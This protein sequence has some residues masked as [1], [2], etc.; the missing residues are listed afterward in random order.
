MITGGK[1]NL[2]HEILHTSEDDLIKNKS[3]EDWYNGL[4]KGTRMGIQV[5]AS[6]AGNLGYNFLS[7]KRRTTAG[8]VMSG[9][10]D[11]AIATGN[12][13]AIAGGLALKGIGALT[14]NIWGNDAEAMRRYSGHINGIMSQDFSGDPVAAINN[15]MSGIKI[16]RGDFG[17]ANGK[18]YRNAVNRQEFALKKADLSG[19]NALDINNRK[20]INDQ[21]SVWHA[22]GGPLVE[23]DTPIGYS[24]LNQE[25]I[26][27]KNKNRNDSFMP[28]LFAG[29]GGVMPGLGLGYDD[30]VSYIG[31]GGTHEE[32]LYGGVPQGIAPDGNPNLVEEGEYKVRLRDGEEMFSERLTVPEFP[33]QKGQQLTKAQKTANRYHTKRGR[34]F[35]QAI[36]K[37]MQDTGYDESS[38]DPIA[39]DGFFDIA[40]NLKLVQD[41]ER[42]KQQYGEQEDQIANMSPEEFAQM[43]EAEKQQQMAQLQQQQMKQQAMQQQ[44]AQQQGMPE[45][46]GEI[47]PQMAQGQG[48]PMMPP[49]GLMGAYGGHL[50]AAGDTLNSS[51]VQDVSSFEQMLAALGKTKDDYY[52]WWNALPREEKERYVQEMRKE[53]YIA[54]GDYHN[55][56]ND[57]YIM[58]SGGKGILIN[59][60]AARSYLHS[61]GV[62]GGESQQQTYTQPQQSIQ[63]QPQQRAYTQDEVR[64]AQNRLREIYRRNK[65]NPGEVSQTV[66]N[67]DIQA[68]LDNPNLKIAELERQVPSIQSV[69]RSG[70]RGRNKRTA[71][72]NR[73]GG[74]RN[75]EDFLL[76]SGRGTLISPKDG[77]FQHVW[78]D[79]KEFKPLTQLNDLQYDPKTQTWTMGENPLDLSADSSSIFYPTGTQTTTT[80][81]MSKEDLEKYQQ[82]YRDAITQRFMDL[83]G[84]NYN[85]DNLEHY[86]LKKQEL[87]DWLDALERAEG[88]FEYDGRTYT[89]E[90]Q[91]KLAELVR[92]IWNFDQTSEYDT[93]VER[94]W[95]VEQYKTNGKQTDTLPGIQHIP[96]E[97]GSQTTTGNLR[98]KVGRIK[99]GDKEY[100]VQYDTN[101]P[102]YTFGDTP[103]AMGNLD[104]YD[105][106]GGTQGYHIAVLPN[107]RYALLDPSQADK[108]KDYVIDNEGQPTFE[109]DPLGYNHTT[110]F[111]DFSKGDDPY[112]ALG[113]TGEGDPFPMAPNWPFKA[114]I[115]AAALPTL[116]NILTP[117]DFSNANAMIN[118][119]KQAGRYMPVS[120]TP[121]G[122]YERYNPT[123]DME[124]EILSSTAGIN[125][126]I[127]NAGLNPGQQMAGIIANN[128]TGI[129]AAGKNRLDTASANQQ[130]RLAV[131]GINNDIGKFNS[132][133]M[134]KADMANQDA[135]SRAMAASLQGTMAGY[136]MKE[137][138]A[139]NKANAISAGLTNVANM[140]YN[141]AQNR[142]N[143]ELLGW[144][145]RNG[146]WEAMRGV[147][148]SVTSNPVYIQT[149]GIIGGRTVTAYGGTVEKKKKKSTKRRKNGLTF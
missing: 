77:K 5:G 54:S 87:S 83:K 41:Q 91:R 10:G 122:T 99:V 76:E 68:V 43:K 64:R 67:K 42:E 130:Q 144:G 26:N 63:T 120:F 94:P 69:S 16:D 32:N 27:Y 115:I 111:Y 129:E 121:Q 56:D 44:M 92:N 143:N 125:R 107:G 131:T 134:L 137:E 123:P 11:A 39:K 149:P 119:G 34:T 126:G 37:A 96:F 48:A 114:G 40:E 60:P 140:I 20:M 59:L 72:V 23:P 118:A 82:M 2:V 103:T 28:K 4:N 81:G 147:P 1:S 104:V 78:P 58:N 141:G 110:T 97:E 65:I 30:G 86:Y 98:G 66:Y 127:M 75:R 102:W 31:N 52:I 36:R 57:K 38:G 93:P 46:Q 133:G 74:I 101:N 132:E 61:L 116:Y 95:Y 35:A 12:P 24:M 100:Y 139:Q 15:S 22:L 6:T 112:K 70:V 84:D 88:N 14:N 73:E 33:R 146:V 135:F 45:A 53:G 49:M 142:Y 17:W 21:L 80:T 138:I 90:D 55:P 8:G 79:G 50:Y 19:Q 71:Y 47:P 109:D 62:A 106:T 85:A 128:K 145:I 18:D 105:V 113:W 29:G 117:T 25:Q 136:R 13:Y 51:S 124:N 9:L 89:P 7:G 148:S 108:L 3:L